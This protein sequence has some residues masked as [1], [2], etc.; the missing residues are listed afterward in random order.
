[1]T[2]SSRGG[3]DVGRRLPCSAL[4]QAPT[5]ERRLAEGIEFK[6][7]SRAAVVYV[8]G[9]WACWKHVGGPSDRTWRTE[10]GLTTTSQR[11]WSHPTFYTSVTPAKFPFRH[12][13]CADALSYGKGVC[14]LEGKMAGVR[15]PFHRLVLPVGPELALGLAAAFSKPVLLAWFPHRHETVTSTPPVSSGCQTARA[16]R[17]WRRISGRPARRSG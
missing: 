1:M 10:E 3:S 15:T 6:P 12:T 4:N 9:G 17:S 14:Q 5:F 7:I 13:R 2:D 16:W 8:M 11:D